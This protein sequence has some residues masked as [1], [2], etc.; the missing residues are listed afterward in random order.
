MFLTSICGANDIICVSDWQL[1]SIGTSNIRWNILTR[2]IGAT[3]G[4]IP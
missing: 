4:Y 2:I 3:D 1:V